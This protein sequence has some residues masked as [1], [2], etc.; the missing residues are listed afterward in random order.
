MNLVGRDGPGAE[1][2]SVRR[3]PRD[4]CLHWR[5]GCAPTWRRRRRAARWRRPCRIVARPDPARRW[6]VHRI[7]AGVRHGPAQL[8]VSAVCSC[9][10]VPTPPSPKRCRCRLRPMSLRLAN[11]CA[12]I[13]PAS[14]SG[15]VCAD[16]ALARRPVRVLY[17]DPV[18][19]AAA[20][21]LIRVALRS[22]FYDAFDPWLRLIAAA[23]LAQHTV[24]WFYLSSDRYYYLTWFLTLLVCAVWL[25][26]EGLCHA[27]AP[28]PRAMHWLQRHPARLGIRN[29]ARPSRDIH[30]GVRAGTVVRS[31][32]S[33][34]PSVRP[35][36]A[37][38]SA[39]AVRTRPP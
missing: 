22:G 2:G 4:C 3:S 38:R 20:A 37:C 34:S 32:T 39:V 27:A 19:P 12:S 17:H 5:S 8:G 26:D 23:A 30:R 9:C 31:A 16:G 28:G 15:G 21:I 33:E 18:Q 14:M 11:C 13:L 24:A 7:S 6:P 29:A 10:S 1:A 36:S 25:R 35:A